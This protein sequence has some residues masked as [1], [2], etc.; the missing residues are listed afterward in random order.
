MKKTQH[1][2]QE[3]P[4]ASIVLPTTQEKINAISERAEANGFARLGQTFIPEKIFY[5]TNEATAD[6]EA[7]CHLLCDWLG[8]KRTTATAGFSDELG[9]V[10]STYTLK[11]KK[12]HILVDG[13]LAEAPIVCAALVAHQLVHYYLHQVCRLMLTD[14]QQNEELADLATIWLG[15]GVL[16]MNGTAKVAHTKRI[17]NKHP[18]AVIPLCGQYNASQYA[19]EFLGYTHNYAIELDG[20]GGSLLPQVA[21][22]A[23][24]PLKHAMYDSSHVQAYVADAKSKRLVRRTEKILLVAGIIAAIAGFAW[25]KSVQPHHLTASQ[26]SAYDSL[27]LLQ[28][29]YEI[30]QKSVSEKQ[31]TLAQDDIF[32]DRVIEQD[33]SRCESIRNTYNYRVDEFNKSL[34]H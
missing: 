30:C 5:Q 16:I 23:P 12:P 13:N 22:F 10:S 18:A 4:P 31:Q 8:I 19:T 7:M 21:S 28:R 27:K 26:V 25:Y 29:Q 3:T 1:N 9:T 11:A 14:E 24:A 34:D 32:T 15:F 6:I 2:K 33:R 17:S 20:I